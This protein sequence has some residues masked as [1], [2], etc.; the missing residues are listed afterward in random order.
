MFLSKP[1][2]W[3]IWRHKFSQWPSFWESKKAKAKYFLSVWEWTKGWVAFLSRWVR[4]TAFQ[5]EVR[6]QICSKATKTFEFCR[7]SMGEL[8]VS[9][10][11][12]T[13]IH[14]TCY[15]SNFVYCSFGRPYGLVN[16]VMYLKDLSHP[17]HTISDT[18]WWSWLWEEPHILHISHI[19][20]ISHR[21]WEGRLVREEPACPPWL[22]EVNPG[23][24]RI[25]VNHS[26]SW[27]I[28]VNHSQPWRRSI[29]T[30]T[31]PRDNICQ[32]WRRSIIVN[33]SQPWH[34]SFHS[35]SYLTLAQVNHSQSIL[36]DRERLYLQIFS[37]ASPS[38][39]QYWP[40]LS[41]GIIFVNTLPG[42]KYHLSRLPCYVFCICLLTT[43][44]PN[45]RSCV[46]HSTN[47]I[48]RDMKNMI[49]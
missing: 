34:R 15:F 13:S 3:L 12:F 19:V 10:C 33:Y 29:F 16:P 11:L 24:G 41:L 30:N 40:I 14:N 44:N 17:F 26:H 9:A 31:V 36:L 23:A 32:P 21:L 25:I 1:S 46:G 8:D 6:N 48:P 5:A 47:T 42:D 38:S 39:G 43:R 7:K 22:T 27:S 35:Q 49:F 4:G 28:I 20:Y 37:G 45:K 2:D 18:T